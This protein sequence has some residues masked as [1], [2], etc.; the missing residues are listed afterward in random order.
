M[1]VP[2]PVDEIRKMARRLGNG[3]R[4]MAHIILKSDLM[5]SV[6]EGFERRCFPV[7]S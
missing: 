7:Y 4:P 1:T 5:I 6:K 3:Y 2:D